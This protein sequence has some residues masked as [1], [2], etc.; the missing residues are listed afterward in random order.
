MPFFNVDLDLEEQRPAKASSLVIEGILGEG[1]PPSQDALQSSRTL[2]GN[3]A[4]TQ[5]PLL[6]HLLR[7]A[8]P[9]PAY[10]V[11]LG[12]CRDGLPLFFDL[13]DPSPGSMLI[14]AGKRGE[15]GE[16]LRS[17]MVSL[18][19]LNRPEEASYTLLTPCPRAWSAFH[20]DERCFG[21]L[22]PGESS[23]GDL[24][25]GFA[26]I[27]AQRQLAKARPGGLHRRNGSAD[28]PQAAL[29]L[30]IEDLDAVVQLQTEQVLSEL[31]WLVQNGPETGVWVIAALPDEL[32]AEVDPA[33]LEL[34]RT[35]VI[36][37]AG[38]LLSNAPTAAG[39]QWLATAESLPERG[40]F[41][42]RSGG[43]WIEF[44]VPVI[45]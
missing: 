4:L 32:G 19:R 36:G 15:I 37:P 23:A 26:G 25:Q 14:R 33:L 24:I 10:T 12:V 34:F 8:G 6:S 3:R 35:Q 1:A 39:R 41:R 42:V 38:T 7:R 30:A 18:S 5:R 31:R 20:G 9:L 44:S 16:I 45:D 29:V 22:E 2:P 11:L 21:I 43:E 27:A 13:S 40:P 17:M 28:Q